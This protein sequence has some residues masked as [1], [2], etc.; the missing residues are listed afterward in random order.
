VKVEE[1]T[2]RNGGPS[3]L[4]KYV[5]TLYF[6]I[7]LSKRLMDPKKDEGWKDATYVFPLY[8][9][10]ILRLTD[11]DQVSGKSGHLLFV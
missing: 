8:F 9:L 4:S 11:W 6:L 3:T 10:R 5:A 1:D 7:P 2:K